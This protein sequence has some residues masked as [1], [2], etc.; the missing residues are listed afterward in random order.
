MVQN[1]DCEMRC[2]NN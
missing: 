2:N 1:S